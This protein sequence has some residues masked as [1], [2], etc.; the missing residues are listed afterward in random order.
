MARGEQAEQAAMQSEAL[1]L[2]LFRDMPQATVLADTDR[3]IV[4]VNPAFTRIFGFEPDEVVGEKT[5]V[6]YAA[7]AD[8]TTQGKKRFNPSAGECPEPYLVHYCRKDGSV[9]PGETIGTAIHDRDGVVSGYL[10]I[11]TDATDRLA[12]EREREQLMERVFQSQ[13]LDSLGLLAGGVAHDFNNMLVAVLANAD[14]ARDSV[15]EGSP[16]TTYLEEIESAARRAADLARDMLALAG[17]AKIRAEPVRL[18]ELVREISS[19]A[20]A[21]ISKKA[22]LEFDFGDADLAMECDP[23]QLRQV[24][25]NLMMNAAQALP[26]GVGTVRVATGSVDADAA[27]LRA[28]GSLLRPGRYVWIEVEDDGPGIDPETRSKIFDPFF[29]TKESGRGLGLATVLGIVRAHNGVVH[30]DSTPGGGSRFRCSLPCGELIPAAP[31]P[32]AAPAR[33]VSGRGSILVIDDAEFV[34]RA[35]SRIL[36][37]QG[38]RVVAIDDGEAG[39]AAFRE[40][41]DAVDAVVLD[42]NLPSI[43]GCEV[44]KA[45]RSDRSDLP[46]VLIS[47]RDVTIFPELAEI[48]AASAITTFL[49]KPFDAGALLQSLEQVTTVVR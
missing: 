49:P 7:P 23:T 40:H 2:A 35:A 38:Y 44:L 37:R 30:V 47:G 17:Q 33:V 43:D 14:L 4:M 42:L 15:D 32:A 28:A 9:F 11:I 3:R 5:R 1:L 41:P 21:T 10:G 27:Y 22:V 26:G 39:V 16:I 20:A 31:R 29:T 45:L 24:V 36:E 13:K 34:R 25:L 18:N 46:I 48:A 12:A 6:L 8:Y 19:L